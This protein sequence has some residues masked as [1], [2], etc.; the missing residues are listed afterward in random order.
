MPV[1]NKVKKKNCIL[2]V[3]IIVMDF[4][5]MAATDGIFILKHFLVLS[6]IPNAFIQAYSFQEYV[7]TDKLK[8]WTGIYKVNTGTV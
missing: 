7:L 8:N 1:S 4:C 2:L 5:L 3:E 6:I